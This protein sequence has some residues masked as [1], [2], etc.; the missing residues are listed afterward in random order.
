MPLK[1]KY[2]EMSGLSGYLPG[3]LEV[4]PDI[5]KVLLENCHSLEKLA[6]EHLLLDSEDIEHICQ[7]FRTLKVLN[8]AGVNF[9]S[10]YYPSLKLFKQCVELKELNLSNW[11]GN[12]TPKDMTAILSN[13]NPKI[14]KLDLSCNCFLG[15][16]HLKTLV[17]RCNKI[18]ELNLGSTS[19]T[20]YSVDSIVTQLK[21]LEKLDVSHTKIDSTALLQLGSVETLKFLRLTKSDQIIKNLRKKLPHLSINTKYLSD[22][23]TSTSNTVQYE[24]GF[25]EIKAR[26]QKLFLK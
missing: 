20:K 15:D 22:I 7:N 10:N 14:L 16:H 3:T 19:I 12:V 8:L 2:L 24:N 6:M 21:S 23:A 17:E 18:T 1:L 26:S 25:W 5:P 9:W 4:L 13:L 11:C